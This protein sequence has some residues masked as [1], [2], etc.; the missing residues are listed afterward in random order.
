MLLTMALVCAMLFRAQA[1]FGLFKL[2]MYAQPF[3]LSALVLGWSRLSPGRLKTFGLACLVALVPLQWSTQK[4]YVTM[5]STGSSA[6][7]ETPGASQE[8]LLSQYR[9]SLRI[10]GGKRFLVPVHDLV[11]CR[12]L[13]CLGQGV[14]VCTPFEEPKLLVAPHDLEEADKWKRGESTT[15]ERGIRSELQWVF[16]KSRGPGAIA[17]HDPEIPGGVSDLTWET[18]AWVDRPQAG[19][20]L[21]QPP[22]RFEL[23]NRF[24]RTPEKSSA[25]AVPLSEVHN[26]IFWRQTSR[27]KVFSPASEESGLSSIQGDPFFPAATFVA[28]GRYISFQ[29]LNPSPRVRVL[30]AG[31]ATAIAGEQTLQTVSVVGDK[32]VSVPLTGQGSARVVSEPVSV[33][34]VWD[35]NF[36]MLDLGNP[37]PP[38]E[39]KNPFMWDPRRISLY[40]RDVSLLTE[41]EYAAMRPPEGVKTF[42]DGLTEKTLEY[43]GCAEEGSVGRQSWFRLTSPGPAAALVVRGKLPK[44]PGLT[45]LKNELVVRWNGAELGR[46][47]I[48]ADEFEWRAPAPV[49]A[50]AGKLELE[51]ARAYSSP[52]ALPRSVSAKLTSLGFEQ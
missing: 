33:Q 20:F 52:P 2:A 23:F 9:D 12:L 1:A 35:S 47:S 31:S 19:D 40:V 16:T 17:L 3:I 36:L 10:P 14:T 13:G 18:P 7:G 30:L 45:A 46:A 11:S 49:A 26:Y 21:L 28:S 4:K 38:P 37:T 51:F 48:N 44:A 15:K 29:V 8:H 22:L 39:S 34:H 42:P 6:G 43:S 50:G 25:R 24:G 32:R 27:S 41:E 5:S